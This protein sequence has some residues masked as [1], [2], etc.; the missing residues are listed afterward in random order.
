MS[1]VHP[2]IAP[3]RDTPAPIFIGGHSASL[4]G[5]IVHIVRDALFKPDAGQVITAGDHFT[6]MPQGRRRKVRAQV[7]LTKGSDQSDHHAR[8]ATDFEDAA[9]V[10]RQNAADLDQ[11]CLPVVRVGSAR[12]PAVRA[13]G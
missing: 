1:S 5:Q 6:Y 13:R 9:G 7:I 2:A 10:A 8:A 12:S 4:S 3:T 11:V